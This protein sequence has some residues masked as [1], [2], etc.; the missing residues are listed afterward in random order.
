MSPKEADLPTLGGIARAMQ[1][2]GNYRID[3]KDGVNG[4]IEAVAEKNE[5]GKSQKVIIRVTESKVT[6]TTILVE[7]AETLEELPTSCFAEW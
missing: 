3:L 4:V 2:V 5:G 7:T 1:G 6:R